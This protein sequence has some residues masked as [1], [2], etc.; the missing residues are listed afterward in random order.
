MLSKGRQGQAFIGS[1]WVSG[2]RDAATLEGR[3]HG[4]AE[5]NTTSANQS[6]DAGVIEKADRGARARR[7]IW[8]EPDYATKR[9]AK[10][11]KEGP[12]KTLTGPTISVACV[13]PRR[14]V[15]GLSH[16]AYG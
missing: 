8:K 2:I 5:R 6:F 1:C 13:P 16:L 12:G 11:M 7:P 4:A 15:V 3:E 10:K 14:H 9:G